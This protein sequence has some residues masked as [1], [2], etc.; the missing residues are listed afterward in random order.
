[1]NTEKKLELLREIRLENQKNQQLLEERQRILGIPVKSH[2]ENVLY[3]HE[4]VNTHVKFNGLRLRILCAL[5]L[6]GGFIVFQ[7]LDIQYQ[8]ID[9]GRVVDEITRTVS[10]EQLIQNG[11]VLFVNEETGV[12]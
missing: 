8:G 11:R 10:M 2:T 3:E 4:P 6:L 9:A 7:R 1:M 12:K 5:L